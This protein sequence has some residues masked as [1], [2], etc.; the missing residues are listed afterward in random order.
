MGL[1]RWNA[2]NDLVAPEP[3]DG[4]E[5]LRLALE[6]SGVGTWEIRP[7]T[8]E[9]VLS[10]RSR[11]LLGIAGEEA[12]SS[13][14]LLA[15]LHPDDRERWKDAI[16]QVLDAERSGECHLVFRTAGRAERWLAAS[17]LA[18]FQGLRVV[19][20]TGTLQDITEQKRTEA[21]GERS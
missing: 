14:R 10:A 15:A 11:E 13:Q 20:V 4:E 17:G 18:S 5:D 1:N 12:I 3:R 7:A 2:A 19:R 9:H 8:G 6:A 16:A 21:V